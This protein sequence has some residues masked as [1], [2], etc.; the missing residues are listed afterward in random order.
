MVKKA[1][2]QESSQGPPEPL[3]SEA[4]W[5]WYWSGTEQNDRNDWPTALTKWRF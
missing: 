4:A 3:S 2:Q 1:D 5:S